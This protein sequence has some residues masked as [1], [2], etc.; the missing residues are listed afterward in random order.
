MDK[1]LKI[2][3]FVVRRHHA[4]E[5]QRRPGQCRRRR[6]RRKIGMEIGR[7]AH[8][9]H[10]GKASHRSAIA[11]PQ[12]RWQARDGRQGATMEQ[13]RT[14]A[15]QTLS[16][17]PNRL[18]DRTAA[19]KAVK[20]AGQRNRCAECLC[21]MRC[22]GGASYRA[23]LHCRVCNCMVCQ[24]ARCDQRGQRERV[25]PWGRCLMEKS[26]AQCCGAQPPTAGPWPLHRPP[27]PPAAPCQNWAG[28][29][30]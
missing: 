20:S 16:G 21:S 27:A 12:D 2:G 5:A 11:R 30:H 18:D 17:A 8:G 28:A 26:S 6:R 13:R 23:H 4:T 15:S 10:C 19:Q 29:V 14:W 22:G 7:K 25:C 1:A 3:F 24:Q 9:V